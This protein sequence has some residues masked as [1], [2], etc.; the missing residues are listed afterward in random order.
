MERRDTLRF[1]KILN[2]VESLRLSKTVRT[3]TSSL[4]IR[5]NQDVIGELPNLLTRVIKADGCSWMSS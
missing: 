3:S 5:I 4:H 2:L 1:I